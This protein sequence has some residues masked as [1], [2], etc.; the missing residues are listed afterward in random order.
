MKYSIFSE[1]FYE[2]SSPTTFFL[3]VLAAKT[4]SQIILQES[5]IITPE[6]PYEEFV[7]QNSDVR[8]I[9]LAVEKGVSFRVVYKAEV[10]V[11]YTT[12]ARK[13]LLGSIPFIALPNEVQP[14][15]SPSRYC[16]SDKLI[17][18]ATEKFGDLADNYSKVV[19]ITDWIFTTIKYKS[20]V[21]T[22]S[23]SA[24]DTLVSKEGVC[25]DFAHLAIALCR[26]LDIPAR[27]FTGYASHLSPPDFHACF[28]AYLGGHWIFFDATK[29]S[30]SAGLV[31]IATA[32]DA[33]E[34][35]V[36]SYYGDA[37]CTF[38][39]VQCC[40]IP[41]DFTFSCSKFDEEAISYD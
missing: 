18:F 10:E 32:R 34:I 16:E 41:A 24:M 25:K 26:A 36:A 40:P 5:L 14:Y 17:A 4:S 11:N 8:F 27:Y 22:G 35:P 9:K 33:S 39:D 29:L 20:G 30:R 3:N 21:S 31:K 23:T 15:I 13:S 28:E 7:L 6:I 2:V 1:L 12:I 19:A 38:M 37:V